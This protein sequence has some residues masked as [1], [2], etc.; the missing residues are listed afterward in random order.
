MA[1]PNPRHEARDDVEA[2]ARRVSK[3]FRLAERSGDAGWTI[4]YAVDGDGSL[5]K[6]SVKRDGEM[7]TALIESPYRLCCPSQAESTLDDI[8][9]ERGRWAPTS[10]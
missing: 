3:D 2:R 4:V 7:T 1:N 8:T 6:E 10:T 5:L 9:L